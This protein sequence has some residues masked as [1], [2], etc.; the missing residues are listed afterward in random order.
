VATNT[1]GARKFTFFNCARSYI[2]WTDHLSPL[3]R[4]FFDSNL[5][6]FSYFLQSAL[7]HLLDHISSY[8]PASVTK[9]DNKESLSLAA[10]K[11]LCE[12]SNLLDPAG[13]PP[14]LP[15][16]G[17]VAQWLQKAIAAREA[18]MAYFSEAKGE[19]LEEVV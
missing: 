5:S 13:Y 8:A 19:K 14:H 17:I 2:C 3:I 4:L 9:I 10:V 7:N 1:D 6:P 11:E 15:V 16:L 12:K 18:A